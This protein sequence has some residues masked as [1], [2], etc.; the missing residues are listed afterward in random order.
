MT[1]K[2]TIRDIARLAGVSKST[3]SRVLNSHPNVDSETRERILNVMREHGFIPNAAATG[4]AKGHSRLIGFLV[5]ALTWELVADVLQGAAAIL[6]DTQYE[7]ILYSAS[8]EKDFSQVIDRMLSTN[9][10][11]GILALLHMQS[12]QHLV[13]LHNQGLPVVLINHVATHVELPQV[14]VDNVEASYTAIRHLLDTGHRRIGFI[15]GLPE[16]QCTHD[17]YE[18]YC[19][20]LSEAG[21]PLDPTLVLQG[22]YQCEGGSECAHRF[23]SMSEPPTAI[24]ASNDLTAYGVLEAANEQGVQIPQ[25]MALIG[26][27]DIPPSAHM[28]PALTTVHQ[29]FREMGRSAAQLLLTMIHQRESLSTEQ[30]ISQHSVDEQSTEFPRILLPTHLVMRKSSGVAQI[31]QSNSIVIST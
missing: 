28:Q 30:Q 26:F 1:S 7:I 9:M 17:R 29:P 22:D 31:A 21:I 27:D 13:E 3:V 24:F 19:K 6:E 23:F 25:D 10:A 18:G 2:L 12:P 5:P 4:L 14:Y 20:A 8:P 15:L 16:F 11:V